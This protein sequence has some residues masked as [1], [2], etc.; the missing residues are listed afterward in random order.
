MPG[1]ALPDPPLSDGVIALREFESTD[2]AALVAACQDP[3]IP[4]FTLVPSPYTEEHARAWLRRVADGRAAGARMTFAIVDAPAGDALLG[5]AG[6]NVIDHAQRTADVG[7]W[8]AA[9]A[10]G[11]GV[12]TRAVELI[13]A[14][15][16]DTLGLARLELRAQEHNHASRAVAGRAGFM[17]VDAPVVYRPECDHL[18]DVF[19]ARLPPGTTHE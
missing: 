16:F 3:E 10:R 2:V 9:P 5:A 1:L 15:S 18:P 4:R 11:R 17:P 14:W 12:A 8:L 13:A 6:L 19:Y 7:Y